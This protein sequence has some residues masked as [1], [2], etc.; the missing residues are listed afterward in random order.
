MKRILAILI[1]LY[2]SVFLVG[3][4]SAF[5]DAGPYV[6]DEAD[7]LSDTEEA[8]LAALAMD[9]TE[10]YPINVYVAAVNDFYDLGA[11]NAYDA[12][13]VFYRNNDLGYGAGRDGMLLLLSMA[14]RDYALVAYGDYATTNLTDYG[15]QKLSEEFLDDFRDN[16]WFGGFEDYFKV[17]KD[18]LYQAKIDKPVDIY[19]K[20][21][22]DPKKVRSLGAAIS[23]L[24][25]CPAALLTGAG[26]KSKLRSVKPASSANQYLNAGSVNFSDRSEIFTHTTQVRTPIP[27]QSRDEGHSS[28][29]GGGSHIDSDGFAGH[30]G[31]F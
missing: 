7:L 14:D 12:A 28:F 5:A 9:I 30:S 2:L 8:D 31:K 26:M 6:F 11:S 29:G 4:M 22:P 15:R 1:A 21:P 16:D 19:P 23:L 17:T 18:Y 13:K 3:G 10:E 24:L 27:R 25:G 20:E